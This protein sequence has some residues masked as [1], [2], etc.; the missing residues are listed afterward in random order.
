M[1]S[2]TNNDTT[3]RSLTDGPI[4]AVPDSSSPAEHNDDWASSLWDDGWEGQT[5][6]FGQV[7]LCVATKKWGDGTEDVFIAHNPYDDGNTAIAYAHRYGDGVTSLPVQGPAN[8]VVATVTSVW[9]PPPQE[10]ETEI[11]S[12]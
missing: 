2:D 3:D 5:G 12:S 4:Q 1:L 9:G 7:H 11:S 8:D 6:L 10:K